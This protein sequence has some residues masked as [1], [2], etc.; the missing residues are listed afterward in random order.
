MGDNA[1][2]LEHTCIFPGDYVDDGA[3]YQ[4]WPAVPFEAMPE[5]STS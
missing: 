1:C 3:T 5:A 2:L 4:G